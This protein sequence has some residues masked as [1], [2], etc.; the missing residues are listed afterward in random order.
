MQDEMAGRNEIMDVESVRKMLI[1]LAD[2]DY[3][4]F[5]S[6]LVP[7]TE[8]ILGVRVPKLRK[9]A[10]K[11]VKENWREYFEAAPNMYYEEDMLR[12]FMVGYGKM[13]LEERLERIRE[14]LPS[15]HNWAVCDCFCSTLKFTEKH[16]ET[17]WEFLK[18][19]FTSDKTY[20]LRFA[21]VMALDYYTLP[22]YAH[23]VFHY[24]DHMKNSDYYVQMAVA[25][26]VSVFYVRLPEVTETY[27]RK[28]RM[29]DFTHNK[30]I[31][32][33]C[34]SYRVDKETKARLRS[35]KRK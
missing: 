25:W 15:I 10:K 31:Q 9:L 6:K 28:N 23:D 7:G 32:K 26:A 20:D 17:V 13:N 14:F 12:G 34:E 4:A 24:F 29:D 5:H 33:I 22:E 3:R 19:C 11:L 30:A 27:I 2:E 8:N 16:R 18:P 1:E 35:L 21:S